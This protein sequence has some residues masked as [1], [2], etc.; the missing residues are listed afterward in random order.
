MRLQ[1][2]IG[3]TE[4]MDRTFRD[5]R[6][7][8]DVMGG[9][10]TLMCGD[11]RQ[12]LPVLRGGTRA[13]VVDE[14]LKR[15]ELWQNVTIY[16]LKDNIRAALSGNPDAALFS[17]M[18]LRIG[19]GAVPFISPPDV[20]PLTEFGTAVQ[21]DE[22]LIQKLSPYVVQNFQNETPLW[23]SKRAILAPLKTLTAL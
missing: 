14:C 9:L 21:T 7:N 15:S 20:I 18:L 4:A 10:P 6:G 17:D 1:C 2:S 3:K 13:N 19:N 8:E 5:R 23:L 16:N 12:I 11:F 22:E